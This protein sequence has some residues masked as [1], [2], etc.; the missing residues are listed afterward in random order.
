MSNDCLI[1]NR[2][3]K[4]KEKT[5]RYFVKELKTGYVVI[6]DYQFYKGYTLFLAKKHV[7][8]LHE[9]DDEYRKEFLYEMSLVAK[10][11][12]KAFQPEKLNYELLG[13]AVPHLHWHL[14]PRYKDDPNP[15]M[16]IWVIDKKIRSNEETLVKDDELEKL[17]KRLISQL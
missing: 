5:N 12:F 14:F 10:A 3:E 6:G 17:K 11:V 16:P 13:N 2:I 4:I 7:A 15:N 1:C 8:E 9:L